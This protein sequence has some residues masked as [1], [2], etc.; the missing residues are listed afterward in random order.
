[1]LSTHNLLGI[2]IRMSSA[3]SPFALVSAFTSKPFGGNPA[4]VVFVDPS[5]PVDLGGL[6]GNFNQPMLCC[7]S[8]TSL[9]SDDK[10]IVVRG[11]RFFVPNGKEMPICGH[12]TLAA[13][14]VLFEQPAII[15]TGA[16]TIHF[17]TSNGNTLKAVKLEDGFIE[18]DLP[19]AV[20]GVLS[21]DEKSKLKTSVDKAFG[22]NVV[23][24]DIKSGGE[25]YEPCMFNF[26]TSTKETP[27]QISLQM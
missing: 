10:K 8:P 22:R 27:I 15:A 19:S 25:V 23:I 26:I 21:A 17:K 2:S 24:H 13:A 11:V 14:K 6:A 20:L 1:M 12:A 5:L 16:H 18:I 3:G 7:V 4:A 9:P